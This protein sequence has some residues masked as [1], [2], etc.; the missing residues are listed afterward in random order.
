M[1]RRELALSK[2]TPLD[3]EVW[4]ILV[5]PANMGPLNLPELMP[6]MTETEIDTSLHHLNELGMI[7]FHP[8]RCDQIQDTY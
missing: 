4:A 7:D 2:M 8:C 5:G 3:K 1:N 6:Q